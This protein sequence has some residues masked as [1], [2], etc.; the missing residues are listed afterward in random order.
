[1][2]PLKFIVVGTGRCGTRY[3]AE[4]LTQAGIPCGHEWVYSP[5]AR[6]N[7][8]IAILGDSSAQA[9]PFV[10]DFPGFVF[11]QVRHPLRVIGSFLGFGLFHDYRQFGPDG[12]FMARHFRF[13]GDVL[14]DAMRYYVEWNTRCERFAR[15]LRYRVEDVNHDLVRRI[16]G[17]IGVT[18][19]D[20]GIARALETV[21][22]NTHTLHNFQ[23]VTWDDLPAG[24][25]KED[26]IRI[27][28]RY[29]YD[30]PRS[31]RL[32]AFGVGRLSGWAWRALGARAAG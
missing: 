4:L 11:H 32:S 8:H 24:A 18:A 19:D 22:T 6:R 16:A 23:T 15:Y 5:H 27:A 14:G 3:I 30:V 1:M 17:A 13:T 31:R 28:A 9:A 26:L 2:E 21:P 25:A 10:P 29:R 20:R 12:E 7:P